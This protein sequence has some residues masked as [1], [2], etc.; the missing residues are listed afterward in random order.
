M[1][2]I[3]TLINRLTQA[4]SVLILA[5]GSSGDGLASGL[6]L[7]AFLSKLE[8]DVALLAIDQISDR[9]AFLPHVS[10]VLSEVDLTKSFVI[11]VSTKRSPLGELS[12]KKEEDRLSIFVK[13][14]AGQFTP[15]DVSFRTSN[16]PYELVIVI[17]VG[18]FEQLG[19]FYA[20]NTGLFFET[21][22]VNIDFRATNENF[23]QINLVNLQATSC[24]E[25]VLDLINE[26]EASLLD[27]IIAT[28]LL[29]GIIA[30]TNSFQH[31][32][33]T[34]QTFIKASQLVSLG[35]KQ[36][37]IIGS[38]YKTKSLGLL[39]L[40]GRVLAR[41]QQEESYN[42]IYSSLNTN[43]IV[44]SG[45]SMNDIENIIKEMGLQLTFAKT[46]LFFAEGAPDQVWVYCMSSLPMNL[47]SLFAAFNPQV[48]NNQTV[49]FSL[50]MNLTECETL[51]LGLLKAEAAKFTQAV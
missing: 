11:D 22:V 15:Q 8:K 45:A 40:W 1:E 17:G 47:A 20:K 19:E 49:K 48:I 9:F 41:L 10:E 33:T 37:D 36:Q 32:R 7:R 50:N 16:F 27:E 12:Y 14:T 38:L 46:S 31:I 2:A 13:P 4:S 35:A 6:A 26:F 51:V 24:S 43:D 39:K 18:S 23:G 44:R 30:E 29:A 25:I 5:S 42:L 21:P 28:Q 3:K 34:P